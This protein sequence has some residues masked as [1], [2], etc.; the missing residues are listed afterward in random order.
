MYH[1]ITNY[2]LQNIN[3]VDFKFHPL[4]LITD[5]S[6]AV[7]YKSLLLSFPLQSLVL[8]NTIQEVSSAFAVVDMLDSDIDSE[9]FKSQIH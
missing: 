8:L 3:I 1:I 2:Y 6:F 5:L 4:I 9:K 7:Y